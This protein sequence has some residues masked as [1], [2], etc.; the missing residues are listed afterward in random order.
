ME[1]EGREKGRD[2][3]PRAVA[4]LTCAAACRH[5]PACAARNPSA[6]FPPH[7][8]SRLPKPRRTPMPQEGLAMSRSLAWEAAAAG[9][10]E[11][12]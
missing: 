7:P 2:A 8:R 11:G 5:C 3:Y 4:A 10:W 1:R 12:R 6:T 9:V